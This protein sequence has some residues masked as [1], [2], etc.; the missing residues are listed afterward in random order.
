MNI[1]LRSDTVRHGYF[2]FVDHHFYISPTSC[3]DLV[4]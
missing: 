4:P 3:L 2:D 1:K